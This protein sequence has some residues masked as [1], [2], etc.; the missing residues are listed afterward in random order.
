VKKKYIIPVI[1]IAILAVAIYLFLGS[2]NIYTVKATVV[3]AGSPVDAPEVTSR[4]DFGDVPQGD[5]LTRTVL[6][7]NTG[8][9]DRSIKIWVIGS[10]GQIMAIE[11]GNSFDLEAGTSQDVN[12][13][14]TMPDSAREGKKYSGRVIIVET[15]WLS[16]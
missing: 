6:L 7:E 4:L 9:N 8:D 11:P 13:V 15:P 16:K 3:E 1:I 14:L 2:S 5:Q 12:F 10:A